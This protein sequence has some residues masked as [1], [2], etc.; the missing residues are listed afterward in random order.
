MF[1]TLLA[2]VVLL[3]AAGTGTYWYQRE[4][5]T[6]L[7][8]LRTAPIIRGELLFSIEAT[9]TAE[10]EEVV[11][12]GAQVAGKIQSLGVDP[13]DANRSIDYGSPVAVGTILARVD[14]ALYQSDVEQAQAEVQS[15]QAHQY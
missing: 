4:A 13:R 12:V 9:G 15:A 1:K 10:P 2:T 5:E 11:D 8:Q 3:A 7:S 6:K 14:D